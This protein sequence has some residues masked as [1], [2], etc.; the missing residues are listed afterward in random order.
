MNV[1][2]LA[3]ASIK[4]P[5]VLP[6]LR[7]HVVLYVEQGILSGLPPEPPCAPQA[8]FLPKGV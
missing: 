1:P 2:I 7:T 8:T 4:E 3:L 5:G 6:L